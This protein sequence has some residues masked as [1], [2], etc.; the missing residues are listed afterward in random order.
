MSQDEKLNE[1]Q[2]TGA[3]ENEAGNENDTQQHADPDYEKMYNDVNDK[4]L[5]LYSEF[6][7]FRKRTSKERLELIKS[8]GSDFL[9]SI[10]PVL[11]D[12]ERAMKVNETTDDLEGV[13]EGFRL[14][15][16]KFSRILQNKGLK[17]MELIGEAFNS[18]VA[19]AIANIPVQEEN[20]KGKI[21]DV[22]EN[23][24]YLNDAVIRYAKVVVGQ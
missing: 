6:D 18:D 3:V 5:R 22:V 8:A 7:N 12:F 4:Y 23:G 2:E 21:V 10:L 19:E 1:E 20:Q 17:Q 15:H 24:Y 16:E 14:I 11:D 9:V 13:K